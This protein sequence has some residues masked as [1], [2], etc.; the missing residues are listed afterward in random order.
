MHPS[1]SRPSLAAALLT[2][3]A[4]A[5]C[6]ENS[7]EEAMVEMPAREKCYGIALAGQNDCANGPGTVNC[8]GT[9]RIDYQSNAWK[10]VDTGACDPL[11]GTLEMTGENLPDDDM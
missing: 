5:A 7:G 9:S 4:L 6:G 8:A 10:A 1:I 11:G 2:G 3:A